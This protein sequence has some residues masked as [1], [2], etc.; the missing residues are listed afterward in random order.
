MRPTFRILRP[1]H[2]SGKVQARNFKFGTETDHEGF[3]QK[4]IKIRSKGIVKWSRDLLLKFKGVNDIWRFG[5][6][7]LGNITFFDFCCFRCVTQYVAVNIRTNCSF[8][9]YHLY[10]CTILPN[11]VNTFSYHKYHPHQMPGLTDKMHYIQFWPGLCLTLRG[12]SH[13]PKC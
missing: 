9:I 4:K 13:S 12:S 7:L 8:Y 10:H 11:V 2:I 1:L 3:L 6:V 5:D